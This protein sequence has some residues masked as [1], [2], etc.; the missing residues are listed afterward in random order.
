MIK[1]SARVIQDESHVDFYVRAVKRAAKILDPK[2]GEDGWG[3]FSESA[4]FV[5][6]DGQRTALM[7]VESIGSVVATPGQAAAEMYPAIRAAVERGGRL[8]WG[9][10][11]EAPHL[12][13]SD[14]MG[15][16]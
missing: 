13:G 4:V 10:V 3:A 1:L 7:R 12:I 14:P 9:D 6:I 15:D 11:P 16:A 2:A 8:A 5:E